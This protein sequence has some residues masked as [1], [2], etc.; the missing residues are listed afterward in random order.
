MCN[1]TIFL[2]LC[3]IYYAVTQGVHLENHVWYLAYFISHNV[4]WLSEGLR[5]WNHIRETDVE[6]MKDPST[7]MISSSSSS[8]S[9]SPRSQHLS[10]S[11]VIISP[12]YV[13]C[14]TLTSES[15]RVNRFWMEWMRKKSKAL[16]QKGL[17]TAKSLSI[18]SLPIESSIM[19]HGKSERRGKYW[20]YPQWNDFIST[21]L[22]SS[23]TLIESKAKVTA[24]TCH[25]SISM[26]SEQKITNI[27]QNPSLLLPLF[28]NAL[29]RLDC[30]TNAMQFIADRLIILNAAQ[31]P[32]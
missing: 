28:Q 4:V 10:H 17:Q 14:E 32:D 6:M 31:P 3:E 24:I 7:Q 29:E 15:L 16:V 18:V 2:F 23:S 11:T 5:V 19:K 26:R 30:C 13:H 27:S 1:R 12:Y 20:Q 22:R 21:S 9:S 25:P 8:S